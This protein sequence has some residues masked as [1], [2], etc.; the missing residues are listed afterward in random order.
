MKKTQPELAKDLLGYLSDVT[1]FQGL[2]KMQARTMS[3][4][5]VK[6]FK[7]YL[8]TPEYGRNSVKGQYLG[9][10]NV[11]ACQKPGAD[12]W[13]LSTRFWYCRDC[14]EKINYDPRQIV[15]IPHYQLPMHG[16]LPKADLRSLAFMFLSADPKQT[17]DQKVSYE[18]RQGFS[19]AQTVLLSLLVNAYLYSGECDTGK[20]AELIMDLE[21]GSDYTV[22][23]DR[24]TEYFPEVSTLLKLLDAF[25]ARL[26]AVEGGT[27]SELYS[28]VL[29]VSEAFKIRWEL[30]AQDKAEA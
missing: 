21:S 11:S 13:N 25:K 2:T 18:Y 3:E 1:N 9:L 6:L 29:S 12:Y 24:R 27:S 4:G 17:P 5:F 14:A 28:Q 7:E 20:L 19:Q 26:Q 10:C 23:L 22:E 8:D 30:L 16:G 15:C